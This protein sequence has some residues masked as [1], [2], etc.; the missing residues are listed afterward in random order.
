MVKTVLFISL[1]VFSLDAS[2][3]LKKTC[4]K[5]HIEANVPNEVV[6]KRYLL[7][8]SSKGKMRKAMVSYLKNPT[9]QKTIMPT[10]F[11]DIFGLKETM[12]LSD[13]ELDKYVNELIDMYDVKNKLYLPTP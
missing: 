13:A 5:C 12:K 3:S 7:K 4:L 9:K 10:R 11:I 6:Y 1:I 8:Y 2:E